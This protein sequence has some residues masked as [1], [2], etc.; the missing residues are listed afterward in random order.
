[1]IFNF[2]TAVGLLLGLA[3]AYP[4]QP[5]YIFAF[6]AFLI[7][8]PHLKLKLNTYNAIYVTA[9]LL[10]IIFSLL[11]NLF[12]D[13]KDQI[14]ISSLIMSSLF[15][16]FFLFGFMIDEPLKVIKGY[17][18]AMTV[19]SIYLIFLFF[20]FAPFKFGLL[21]FIVPHL[22]M[23][24]EGYV[25]DWPN[26]IAF[27]LSLSFLINWL[28]LKKKGLAVVN[29]VAAIITTSRIPILAVVLLV[30][31]YL[32]KKPKQF[33][34]WSSII[35]LLIL[36]SLTIILNINFTVEELDQYVLRLT[37]SGDRE[38]LFDYMFEKLYLENIFFGIGSVKMSSFNLDFSSSSFH[39]S[40]LE[41]MVRFGT[42]T[43][44]P[45]LIL[46]LPFNLYSLKRKSLYVNKNHLFFLSFFLICAFFQ[47]IFKHPHYLMLYVVF[48]INYKKI[49]HH[50]T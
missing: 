2:A 29:L 36:I 26:F 11:S 35:L 15:Y 39:N 41:I 19:I 31:L 37:K 34:L 10:C 6:I 27:G 43:L 44:L 48:L 45:Y 5:F 40:Y 17:S 49:F 13:Y 24:A 28:I 3:I 42:V 9:V 25:G 30:L 46:I 12:S 16:L 4:T 23:W 1:M 18:V 33:F 22:R 8:S 14:E 32:L 21:M 50:D 38:I 7:S 47:N 20:I